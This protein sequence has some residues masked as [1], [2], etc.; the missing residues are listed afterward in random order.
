MARRRRAG[1]RVGRPD[2]QTWPLT[3][4]QWRQI[5]EAIGQD[6]S[7]TDHVHVAGHTLRHGF[8]VAISELIKWIAF[9]QGDAPTTREVAR[10]LSEF[11]DSIVDRFH[12]LSKEAREVWLEPV[13]WPSFDSDLM[14]TVQRFGAWLRVHEAVGR[15]K[16]IRTFLADLYFLLRQCNGVALT[17]PANEYASRAEE[18]PL[19][20][21]TIAGIG[22]ALALAK[23]H[24]PAAVPTLE[25]FQGLQPRTIVKNLRQAR[26]DPPVLPTDLRSLGEP[27]AKSPSKMAGESRR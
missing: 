7:L 12:A 6:L 19:Y 11:C 9:E 15:E 5:A 2:R 16:A 1:S 26:R 21:V 22:V 4:A 20:R 24:V 14:R 27:Q 10:E 3:E 23:R 25:R 8:E 17:L 13:G 18:H